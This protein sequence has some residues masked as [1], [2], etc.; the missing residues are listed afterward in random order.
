[1]YPPK[2]PSAKRNTVRIIRKGGPSLVN[3]SVGMAVVVAFLVPLAWTFWRGEQAELGQQRDL[4]AAQVTWRCERGHLFEAGGQDGARICWICGAIA[5]PIA[6][7]HCE[8]HGPCEVEVQFQTDPEIEKSM[9]SKVRIR[10][11]PWLSPEEGLICP[12]CT[13]PLFYAPPDPLKGKL[14]PNRRLGG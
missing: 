7:Y 6:E 5:Y 3:I 2:A 1:M 14:G 12:R 4:F 8:V 10:G 13:R 9:V 11:G